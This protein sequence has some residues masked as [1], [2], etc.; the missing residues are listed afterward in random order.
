MN[1]VLFGMSGPLARLSLEA[2]LHAGIT[3]VAIVTPALARG[4]VIGPPTT[5]GLVRA[6]G[7]RPLPSLTPV[8]PVSLAALA[9]EHSIPLIDVRSVRSPKTIDAV[10]ALKPDLIAVACFP[11]RLPAELLAMPRLGCVNVHP[12]LLPENRGP[13]PLFWTFRHGE[14][15]T[16]VTIH[17]MTEAFDAGPILRQEKIA[18]ANGISEAL[19][20]RQCAEVGGKLL[21]EVVTGIA[22]GSLT[23]VPQ[24]ERRATY[25]P[26]PGPLD[27]IIDP[28]WSAQRCENF[29]RGVIGRGHPIHLR[30]D[31]A[32]YR[33]LEPLGAAEDGPARGGAQ[34]TDGILTVRR[35]SGVWRA[36][37]APV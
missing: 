9:S 16:G 29:A 10:R 14:I 12:S 17:L 23:P 13:D 1:L 37:V 19:L 7:R 15:H 27:Y 11:W 5:S 22:R 18:V 21:V 28:E 36:R 32:T 3:P 33:V 31:S 24:D 2:L 26:Q 30:T 34:L 6:S 8:A 35:P 20:E 25:Y 4:P